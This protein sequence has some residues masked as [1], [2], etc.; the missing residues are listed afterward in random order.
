MADSEVE[1]LVL[2]QWY[3]EVARN[4]PV[5]NQLMLYANA[6]DAVAKLRL[7]NDLTIDE[8]IQLGALNSLAVEQGW[9]PP[10]TVAGWYPTIITTVEPLLTAIFGAP[11]LPVT[12]LAANQVPRNGSVTAMIANM[13]EA[14]LLAN[15]EGDLDT[16]AYLTD[17]LSAIGVTV[18]YQNE[19]WSF[20]QDGRKITEKTKW[21]QADLPG[22]EPRDSLKQNKL[23]L[24]RW[25]ADEN[26]GF[27]EVLLGQSGTLETM[28]TLLINHPITP[29]EIIALAGL[30]SRAVGAG[31]EPP[32]RLS[33][34]GHAKLPPAV[35]KLASAV[36]RPANYPPHLQGNQ[37]G[38]EQAFCN[39]VDLECIA[40]MQADEAGDSVQ[41]DAILKRLTE[42]G[43]KVDLTARRW[44]FHVPR[45]QTTN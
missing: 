3:P 28:R 5:L 17:K 33:L 8:L 10:T 20:Y 43:V 27:L 40:A 15:R 7:T 18:D 24:Q 1:P 4:A 12:K 22:V 44:D 16:V 13:A 23:V 9:E 2:L 6:L 38:V 36:F 14:L 34:A 19:T 11:K 32:V 39:L 41:R 29:T 25:R 26:P 45:T 30:N 37:M 42:V 35:R 31:M 21:P